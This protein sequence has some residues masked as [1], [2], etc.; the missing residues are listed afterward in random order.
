MGYI[1][2]ISVSQKCLPTYEKDTNLWNPSDYNVNL[3]VNPTVLAPSHKY[4]STRE[5]STSECDQRMLTF[6]LSAT[7]EKMTSV[8]ITSP[9][10]LPTLYS[11]ANERR[12]AVIV[13]FLTQRPP[14]PLGA[15][16]ISKC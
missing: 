9:S 2:I 1:V 10:P 16:R 3:M 8:F 7:T 13:S 4:G 6:P 11:S 15:M 5:L 14:D 12:A